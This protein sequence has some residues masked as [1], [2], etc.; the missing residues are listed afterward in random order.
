MLN[1]LDTSSR[2]WFGV[3]S[4]LSPQLHLHTSKIFQNEFEASVSLTVR[5]TDKTT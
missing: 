5:T 4:A 1:S 2:W 3:V